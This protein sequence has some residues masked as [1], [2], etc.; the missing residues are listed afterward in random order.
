MVL[1][2]LPGRALKLVQIM[3]PLNL[4][5]FAGLQPEV[6]MPP[7]AVLEAIHATHIT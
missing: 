7:E 5:S 6:L 2:D 3:H 1:N 4:L